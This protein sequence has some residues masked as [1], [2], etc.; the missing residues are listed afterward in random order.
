MGI[1]VGIGVRTGAGWE[2]GVDAGVT[3]G[4]DGAATVVCVEGAAR[5]GTEGVERTT[6]V[7]CCAGAAAPEVGPPGAVTAERTGLAD[8]RG[9]AYG[10]LDVRPVDAA[11]WA[12]CERPTEGSRT[13]PVPVTG[14]AGWRASAAAMSLRDAATARPPTAATAAPT[15]VTR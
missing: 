12:R 6:G 10:V 9:G 13:E 1:G 8:C 3:F 2:A 14:G 5:L 7:T 11:G 15:I 4:L